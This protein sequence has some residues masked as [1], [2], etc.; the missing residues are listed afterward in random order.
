MKRK[1][2]KIKDIAKAAGVSSATVSQALNHP[3][4]VG[5]ETRKKII[6]ICHDLGYVRR[7]TSN[8][9]HGNIG[10]IAES[11]ENLVLGEFFNVVLVGILKAAEKHKVSILLETLKEEGDFPLMVSKNLIDGILILGRMPR[12]NILTLAQRNIP[13]LLIEHPIPDIEL[14]TLKSDGKSGMYQA[15]KYLIELGHRR[16]AFVTGGKPHDPVAAERLDGYRFAMNEA[17]LPILDEYI[18]EGNFCHPDSSFEATEKILQ[19]KPKVTAI[20]YS[21]DSLAYRGYK[22]IFKH[23]L[24]IP[25]DIS[26]IG[27]DD[28]P[29]PGLI[30]PI[31]PDLTTIHVHREKTGEVALERLLEIISSAPEMAYRFTLPVTLV[32][33][34]S[35]GKI[36]E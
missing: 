36:R 30:E 29:I 10:V 4:L 9:R 32:V 23:G 11:Y 26:V 12:N 6:E 2:V 34:G 16:I 22:T 1:K 5:R 24:K 20:I 27:F 13:L 25:K 7:L 3:K 19:I 8:K 31:E 17:N 33:R 14:H 28:I 35:T 15:T 21:S 18:A